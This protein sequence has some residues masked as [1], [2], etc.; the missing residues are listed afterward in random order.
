MFTKH[1][2]IRQKPIRTKIH[3]R[4]N[5]LQIEVSYSVVQ[6]LNTAV[7]KPRRRKVRDNT[8]GQRSTLGLT[9]THCPHPLDTRRHICPLWDTQYSL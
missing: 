1:L 6:V 5:F 4:I 3:A 9:G 8:C 2:S 7:D